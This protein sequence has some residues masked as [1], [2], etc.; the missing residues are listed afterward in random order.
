MTIGKIEIGNEVK[1]APVEKNI[2][3]MV[4]KSEIQRSDNTK[5]G[6]FLSL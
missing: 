3:R 4:D 2:V 6:R 1:H 5:A